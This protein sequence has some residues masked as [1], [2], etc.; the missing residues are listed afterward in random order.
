MLFLFPLTIHLLFSCC[1]VYT[2]VYTNVCTARTRPWTRPIHCRVHGRVVHGRYTVHVYKTVYGPCTRPYGRVDD[3]VYG[4]CTH[5][6]CIRP[7]T[8][9]VHDRVHGRTVRVHGRVH[10]RGHSPYTT[11][12]TGRVHG[13]SNVSSLSNVHFTGW[14]SY[15]RWVGVLPHSWGKTPTCESTQK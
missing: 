10:D 7:C 9:C 5:G 8:V 6:P 4:P 3:R 13:L 15:P 11:V 2:A 14:A 12:Y 1:L